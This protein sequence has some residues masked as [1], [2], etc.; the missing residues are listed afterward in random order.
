M[1]GKNTTITGML[2]AA[3]LLQ[4]CVT[5]RYTTESGTRVTAE[6]MQAYLNG[7]NIEPLLPYRAARIDSNMQMLDQ[8]RTMYGVPLTKEVTEQVVSHWSVSNAGEISA[9]RFDPATRSNFGAGKFIVTFTNA[10]VST[11]TLYL[12]PV[13]TSVDVTGT[14]T[15]VMEDGTEISQDADFKSTMIITSLP[16]LFGLDHN[17][18]KSAQYEM[19]VASLISQHEKLRQ[20][21]AREQSLLQDVDRR[22]L[23]TLTAALRNPNIQLLKPDIMASLSNVL[24]ARSDRLDHYQAL[25]REFPAFRQHIPGN[26]QLFFVGPGD[27]Q[28]VDIWRELRKGANPDVT[29]ATIRAAGKP[30]RIYT[31]DEIAWLK[32]QSIPSAVIVAMIDASATPVQTAAPASAPSVSVQSASLQPNQDTVNTTA[33]SDGLAEQCVKAVAAIKACEQIPGDPFG[34]ARGVC[35]KQVKKGLGATTCLGL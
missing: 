1:R 15:L 20:R 26:E 35:V 9:I 21:I 13:Y 32:K 24:A 8:Q 11:F 16:G 31:S 14:M 30:Y 17:I 23:E 25:I 33:Q 2:C 7:D 29:A 10:L 18:T 27:R 19:Q 6:V 34:I 5:A 4:G 28:V 12:L 3:L 22:S